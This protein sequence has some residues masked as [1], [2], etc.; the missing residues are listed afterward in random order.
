M[1]INNFKQIPLKS[2][3]VQAKKSSELSTGRKVLGLRRLEPIHDLF[4]LH[5][6]SGLQLP[7]RLIGAAVLG[8]EAF[9]EIT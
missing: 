2:Y 1:F 3:H 6:Q 4:F 7:N 5:L 8:V 9:F